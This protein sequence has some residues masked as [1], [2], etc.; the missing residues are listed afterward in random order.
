[1]GNKRTFKR[2]E[3]PS[4]L[5]AIP[6]IPISA[7]IGTLPEDGVILR[8]MF[9]SKGTILKAIVYIDEMGKEGVTVQ[10]S[11]AG[12]DYRASFDFDTVKPSISELTD[13]E[14][15]EGNRLTVSVIP[16][17]QVVPRGIWVTILWKPTS[18]RDLVH[19]LKED[20]E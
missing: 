1:M 12:D 19:L 13:L 20:N 17:G 3:T 11:I 10:A 8:H 9:S 4:Q 18:T 6:P 7:G 16:K 5:I 14:V 15:V 2:K